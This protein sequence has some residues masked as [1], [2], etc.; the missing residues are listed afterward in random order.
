MS[1]INKIT[2]G[3]DKGKDNQNIQS[4]ASASSQHLIRKTRHTHHKDITRIW[5]HS[6]LPQKLQ[7]IPELAMNITTYRDRRRYR[8][9][10]GLFHEDV[11]HS[12]AENFHVGFREMLAREE[13]C[14]PFVGS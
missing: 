7:Q 6:A 14:Y 13:L 1:P 3:P 2:L 8:L 5:H 12:I 10:I 9:D 4:N 11:A